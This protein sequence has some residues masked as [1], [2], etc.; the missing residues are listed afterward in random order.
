MML[1]YMTLAINAL[2]CPTK[3]LEFLEGRQDLI[4]RVTPEGELVWRIPARSDIRSDT[5]QI[6]VRLGSTLDI[7]GSPARCMG[8][9]Q[10]NVFGSF[11]ILECFHAVIAF[12]SGVIGCPLPDDPK[13]WDLRRLD[14]TGNYDLGSL[15]NVK[16]ALNYLRHTEGGRYQVKTAA[17]SVYWSPKSRLRAGKAYAK[18]P[19]M[20]YMIGKGK[21]QLCEKRL[22]MAQRL[23]RLELKLGSQF[24]KRDA[25]GPWYDCTSEYLKVV[26]SKFFEQFIGSVE[27]SEMDD[28]LGK[29]QQ[30]ASTAGRAK[31]AYKTWLLIQTHGMEQAR[32][33]TGRSAWY[34]HKAL[35]KQVGISWA[36]MHAQKIVPFRRRTIVLGDPVASWEDLERRCA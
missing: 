3:A 30:I 17:E 35:L 4:M 7:Y 14:V 10:N 6:T 23:L 29:L 9:G 31:A 36:D 18:G 24:W 25:D 1:D 19:H 8:D 12:V 33:L 11:D 27:V 16:Q 22:A 2:E 34:Q 26:H 13:L 20:Q 5:H 32:A 15:A 21:A 28:V